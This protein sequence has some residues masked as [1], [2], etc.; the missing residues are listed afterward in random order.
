MSARMKK[1]PTF[2][3]Y[4]SKQAVEYAKHRSGYAPQLIQYILAHHT[5]TN[6]K[7]GTVLDVGCGP[8]NSTR[9]LAAFFNR[10]TGIDPSREM[11]SVARKIGGMTKEGNPIDY[12]QGEAEA[13]E[14]VPD[15]SVD[16]L[17]AAMS[18]HWFDMEQFWPTAARVLKPG[19]TVALFNVYRMYCPQSQPCGEAIQRILL[20]LD[21]ETLG[22]YLMPGNK[23][24]MSG[25]KGLE[26]PWSL[27]SPCNEF[28]RGSYVRR[29]WNEN[30]VPE[31]DG[32][33][34]CGEKAQSLEDAESSVATS[35]SV[36]R[37]REAHPKAAHT[38]QDCV[39]SAFAS[40]RRILGPG[41][42]MLTTA[43]PTV[44]LLL[45]FL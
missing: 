41:A 32:S 1:D 4:S 28:D 8:G 42:R 7:C 19:G 44:L 15:S 36:T 13:C 11:T 26:M 18:A 34:M 21:F 16:L 17:T 12:L 9:D 24:V 23:E 20:K 30:G 2:T 45:K 3:S 38:D 10:A 5:Q 22:P 27:R 35:S 43:G 33:F 25:Y 37:W 39:V 14:G 6:G 40:I 31:T 29:V